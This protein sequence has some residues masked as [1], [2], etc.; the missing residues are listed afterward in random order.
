ML[1]G[2]G[3]STNILFHALRSDVDF[4][5]VVLEERV[6]A[7]ALI[8]G[9]ARRLGWGRTIGQLLFI[10]ANR[11]LAARS[12]RRVRELLAR[13]GMDV[14]QMP[15]D[16]VE[17]VP[18]VNGPRVVEL[19]Q[20]LTPDA[21]VVN[22]TRIIAPAVL[23]AVAVPFLNG[24]MGMTPRYRGVHGAYWALASNDRAHCGV[25]VHLVDEGVDT[26]GVLYQEVIDVEPDDDFN[27]YPVH[28]LARIIP[29]MRQTL[30]DLIGGTLQVRSGVEPSTL[31][32]HPT[33]F[34]YLKTRLLAG[35]R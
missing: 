19:L 13:Y 4:V 17:R 10:V 8:R 16:L 18:S 29:L 15:A 25:T 3:A 34:G 12:R 31:W 7:A 26:G 27:T 30:T 32:H 23:R 2:P 20:A 6:S 11:L 35:V 24:H 21:V 22:G 9:R 1:A 33:L 14:G 5:R 28:Q